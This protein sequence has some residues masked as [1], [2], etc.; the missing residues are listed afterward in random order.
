M[1]SSNRAPSGELAFPLAPLAGG[2]RSRSR[3]STVSPAGTVTWYQNAALVPVRSGFTVAAPLT[4]WSL[5]PS[6]GYGVIG[7]APNSLATLVSF[8]QNSAV[9]STP[10][11]PAS[12]ISSSG[13]RNG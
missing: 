4:T 6:L 9:G 1:T 5:M 2:G 8:S 12:A 7:W 11:G 13:P 3:N 10:P